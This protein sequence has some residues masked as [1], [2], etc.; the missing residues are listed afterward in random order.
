VAQREARRVLGTGADAD[1]AAQ[2]AILRAWRRQE[3][4]RAHDDPAPWIR[5]IA[6]NEALRIAGR[7][8][9][10]GDPPDEFAVAAPYDERWLDDADLRRRIGCLPPDSRTVLYLRY[11]SGLTQREI[12]ERLGAPEGTVKV[13]LHRARAALRKTWEEDP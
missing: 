5:R 6:A 4:C 11:W 13:R 8:P 2:E 7:R 1:D 9:R 10:F 12:A 3:A